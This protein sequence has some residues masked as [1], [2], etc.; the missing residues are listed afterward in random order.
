VQVPEP[1]LLLLPLLLLPL[2]SPA[3]LS[4]LL[5]DVPVP[6]LLLHKQLTSINMWFSSRWDRKL[7]SQLC[8][9]LWY[10]IL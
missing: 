2:F 4:G 7:L 10:S 8:T 6:E 1:L 9:A 5:E 3:G